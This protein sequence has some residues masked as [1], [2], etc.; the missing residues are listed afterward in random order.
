MCGM[1][2]LPTGEFMKIL[3]ATDGSASSESAAQFLTR[4]SWSRDD[5]IT[6]FHAIYA[7]PF[8]YDE[9]FYFDTLKTIK[10]DIA[11][12]ILDSALAVLKPVQA[13]ISVEIDEFSPDQCTPDQCIIK[14][15]E[16]SGVDLIAMGARGIKGIAAAFLGSVTRL[17]TINSS[18]PVLVV[19]P[20]GRTIPD[21]MK[22]LFAADGSGHSRAAGEIL[23]AIPFPGDTEVTIA[24]IISSSFSDIPERFALEINER[25]KDFV[26][27]ARTM[28]YAVSEKIIEQAGEILSKRY[29]NI[30]VLT[31]VGDPSTELLKTADEMEADVIAVGCRGLT[32]IKGMMGSVSRNVLTHSRCSV[33]I[34]KTC[35]ES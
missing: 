5:S 18:K 27:G 21:R 31:K 28:E 8:H 15:A 1:L 16:A 32:G 17:V 13:A 2:S 33:L 14:A 29:K 24:N 35:K 10:K 3:I 20:S 4:L 26:A 23:S 19:K 7:V 30:H 9:K 34:G 22:I 25:I 12:R 6:V 11:P